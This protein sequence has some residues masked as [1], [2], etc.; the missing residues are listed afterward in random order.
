MELLGELH[1]L[2]W[3]CGCGTP[4]EGQQ[5]RR[6]GSK[7]ALPSSPSSPAVWP[8]CR[9]LRRTQR[10]ADFNLWPRGWIDEA[11]DNGLSASGLEK[12]TAI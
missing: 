8:G 2:A 10:S 4:V 7:D 9:S 6:E 12:S 5:E 1:R 3:G 11:D